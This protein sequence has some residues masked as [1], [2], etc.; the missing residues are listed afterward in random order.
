MR[1][2]GAR[3]KRV[4]DRINT[5]VIAQRDSPR[6][7]RWVRRYLTTITYTGRRS[8]RTF[9]TPVAYRRRGEYVRI[10]VGLPGAKNWWRNF[11]GRGGPLSLELD[12]ATRTG[13]AVA[14]R[15]E[16]GRVVVI[17]RLRG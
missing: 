14:C 9:T 12:G 16:R 8:G 7:G 15:D 13:H 3:T 1:R 17:V 6:W 5:Y 11:T 10:P 2:G 4:V